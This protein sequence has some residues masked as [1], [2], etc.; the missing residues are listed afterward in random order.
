MANISSKDLSEQLRLITLS[1]R[2]DI[3]GTE[4]IELTLTALV[5]GWPN[6]VVDLTEVTFLSSM[7]IRA[8]IVNAKAL[9]NSGGKLVLVL[10]D[11]AAAERTLKVTCADALMP[12]FKTFDEAAASLA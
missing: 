2:M 11:N 7:G 1:E 6:V 3:Q 4:K 5:R 8:L 10:G 9:K 12:M